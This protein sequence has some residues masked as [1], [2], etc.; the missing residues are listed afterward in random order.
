MVRRPLLSRHALAGGIAGDAVRLRCGVVLTYRFDMGCISR[1]V[2]SLL[3]A[4]AL[5]WGIVPTPTAA[6]PAAHESKAIVVLLHGLG[7]SSSAMWLLARRLENAGF[8]V[9][10]IGYRSLDDPPEEILQVIDEKVTA[11]CIGQSHTVHFV[12]HSLGGLLIRAYLAEKPVPDLG[13][14]VVIGTPNKG[15]K[16]V[17][18][19]REDWWFSALGPTA[20]ALGTGSESLT[21]QLPPPSYP[22]GVIAGRSSAIPNDGLLPGADDGL[23]SVEQTKV[24]GMTDFVVID[25]GHSMMRYDKD[26]A[27]QTISF[28]KTGRFVGGE[29]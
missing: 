25:A 4:A 1:K 18:T 26:V 5:V 3:V 7:R 29:Q 10:R 13:R 17:D 9:E 8:Q 6:A 22:L 23:V 19:F 24:S 16:L 20:R 27:N 12:G 21:A 28:L 2:L 15:S 14:V 11:C